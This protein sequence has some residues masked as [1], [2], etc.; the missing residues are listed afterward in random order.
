MVIRADTS[1]LKQLDWWQFGIRFV[2]GGLITAVAGIL[3]EK[4]GPAIGGLFLA[5]PAIFSAS[6]TL[7]E[8]NERENKQKKGLTGD[9]R[10]RAAAMLDAYGAALGSIALMLFA[11]LIWLQVTRHAPWRVLLEATAVWIAGA[12]TA[13]TIARRLR[14][15]HAASRGMSRAS[16]AHITRIDQL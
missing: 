16:S 12:V 5:F 9:E 7:V 10:G 6:V 2:L 1:K 14:H 13:W 8:K 4:L 3:A 15:H 11:V